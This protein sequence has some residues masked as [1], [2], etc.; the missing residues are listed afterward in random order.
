MWKH[1]TSAGHKL[2]NYMVL[3][4]IYIRFVKDSGMVTEELV[5]KD[6]GVQSVKTT[7]HMVSFYQCTLNVSCHMT[8]KN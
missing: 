6:R 4:W 5:L 2:N 7:S 3:L 1:I 8:V